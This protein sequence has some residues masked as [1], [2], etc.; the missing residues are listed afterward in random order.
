MGKPA[1]KYEKTY[2]SAGLRPDAIYNLPAR[3]MF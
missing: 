2:L 1:L 3:Y